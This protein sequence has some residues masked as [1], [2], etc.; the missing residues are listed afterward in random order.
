MT[1]MNKT[2]E[3]VKWYIQDHAMVMSS[4][5]EKM[6]ISVSE[7]SDVRDKYS[8]I[9]FGAQWVLQIF[10]TGLEAGAKIATISSGVGTALAYADLAVFVGDKIS[11]LS[12]EQLIDAIA[13]GRGQ[14]CIYNTSEAIGVVGGSYVDISAFHPRSC[15]MWSDRNGVKVFFL[16]FGL[17]V[18]AASIYLIITRYV[19]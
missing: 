2:V 16:I 12:Q 3:E 6:R 9:S 1:D 8:D 11:A 4:L 14:Y 13:K 19:L 17:L 5:N 7:A 18:L 10:A 15:G